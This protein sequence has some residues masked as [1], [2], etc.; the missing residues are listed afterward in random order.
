MAEQQAIARLRDQVDCP[1]E[2]GG[3]PLAATIP[4]VRRVGLRRSA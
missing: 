2:D 4:P 3:Q 1:F